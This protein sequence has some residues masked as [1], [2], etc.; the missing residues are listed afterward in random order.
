MAALLT[1][2]AG[3]GAAASAVALEARDYGVTGRGEAV[4]EYALRN[5]DG[6]VVKFLSYGGIITAI[7]V[8]DRDGR[9][10][11]V[12]LGLPDLATYEAKNGL[13]YFGGIVGRFAGRIAG[14]RFGIDGRE[15]RLT[16]NDG[17]NAL[18]G[19]STEGFIARNWRVEPLADGQGARLSYVAAD[20]EQG[21]PGRLEV[22]VEYRL[23]PGRALR[24]D[25]AARSDAPTV[26]NLTNHSYFNLAGAAAGP[27]FDH[28]LQLSADR[29]VEATEAG[30][31]TGRFVPVAGTAFDFRQA[32][33][34]GDCLEAAMP[35]ISG[36]CGYN[37]SWL[38]EPSVDGAPVPA[39]RVEEPRSGRTLEV[40]TTE[41]S[42]HA[43]V[44]N[45]FSGEDLGAA[46]VPLAPHTGLALETQHLPDSPNRPEFPTTLLRRGET[47]RS[48]TIYRFGT[49]ND[50]EN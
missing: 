44:A 6:L 7:E 50:G 5:E 23:L 32:R 24:I 28:R 40:S 48:T 13:Y 42:I 49:F 27:V 14:A 22:E 11:N 1:T 16:A 2:L 38:L 35:R 39:A 41:P 43:Y 10:D 47:F 18:H 3:C 21:F 36:Y 30:I 9:S 33:P 34:L 37:H 4:Q 8:P 15:V 46:G 17:P 12:V 25:Y 45:H 31:P 29:L 26:L 19:G 20:G